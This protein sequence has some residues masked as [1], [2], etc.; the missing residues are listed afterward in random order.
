MASVSLATP[1]PG[2]E[3]SRPQGEPRRPIYLSRRRRVGGSPAVP[4]EPSRSE[5]RA[6]GEPAGMCSGPER[7]ACNLRKGAGP[8]GGRGRAGRG[9]PAGRE[10]GALGYRGLRAPRQPAGRLC[11]APE[12]RFWRG[13]SAFR[14]NANRGRKAGGRQRAAGWRSGPSVSREPFRGCI[15][16]S[17]CIL[18]GSLPLEKRESVLFGLHVPC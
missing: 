16:R 11:F 18:A 9:T 1:P 10:A 8:A 12:T 6:R 5:R 2:T 17:G 15:G 4:G 7:R 3:A 13:R 14:G